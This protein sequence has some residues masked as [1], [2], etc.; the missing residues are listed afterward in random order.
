AMGEGISVFDR[1]GRLIAWNSQFAELLKLPAPPT[2][3][4][5]LD[6]ILQTLALRGDFGAIDP[7]RAVRERREKFYREVP[8]IGEFTGATDR[9][10]LIRRNAMPDG[11]VV[12]LYTDI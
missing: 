3:E 8:A 10:L 6:D 7:V 9:T 2:S 5:S 1:H 12:S 11:S 4:T